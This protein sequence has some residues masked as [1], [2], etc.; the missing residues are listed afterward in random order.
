[1]ESGRYRPRNNVERL[2][3]AFVCQL[4]RR[5]AAAARLYGEAIAAD[6]DLPQTAPTGLYNAASSAVRAA[7]GQGIDAGK[8]TD[9]ERAR[10][11]GEALRWLRTD[12][13]RWAK[14][15]EAGGPEE[16]AAAVK[17]LRPW[18]RDATLASV[19]D[20]AGLLKLTADEREAWRAL[21]AEV[22]ALL[23]KAQPKP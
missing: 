18:Q 12:L 10:L 5:F 17:A 19:R 1:V 6:P 8:L 4:K 15:L 21:W 7:D 16:G 3:Y 2:D 9:K 11:R 22:A 23:K 20:L 14:R 13:K